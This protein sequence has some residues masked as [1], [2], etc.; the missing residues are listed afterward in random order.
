MLFV[1]ACAVL[2][3]A[4]D[5][6][7]YWLWAR[8]PEWGYWD[9]PPAVGWM[10]APVVALLP[11]SALAFRLVGLVG[12]LIAVRLVAGVARDLGEG[13]PG[14]TELIFLAG[15]LVAHY[16]TEMGPDS[17]LLLA[18]GLSLY[19]VHRG[20]W[21]LAG[22]GLAL[23]VLSKLSGWA[24]FF[25]FFGYLLSS[26]Q[27]RTRGPWLALFTAILLLIPH[28]V[29]NAQHD[30]LNYTFQWKVRSQNLHPGAHN[31]WKTLEVF[32]DMG[33]LGP[34]AFA[35]VVWAW[36]KPKLRILLWWA[37]PIQIFFLIVRV[38]GP[39]RWNWALPSY[40]PLAALLALWVLEEKRK[41]YRVALGLTLVWTAGSL[42]VRT[43]PALEA[44]VADHAG[45]LFPKAV[46]RPSDLAFALPAVGAKLSEE[47][48]DRFL[49]CNAYT[50]ASALSFY[51]GR[52]VRTVRP[53]NEGSQ[54]LEYNR[55]RELAGQD[56]LLI[57]IQPLEELGTVL[58]WL[59]GSF[60][61]YKRLPTWEVPLANGSVVRFYP[62][63]CKGFRVL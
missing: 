49:V 35:A 32:L 40:L 58:D 20:A 33:F 29:W 9:H 18:W 54:F 48:S 45:K 5:E 10:A 14:Q 3:L 7:Y 23:A 15:P 6:A 57:C 47:F 8:H 44:F 13:R 41:L 61:S 19:G 25:C 12:I 1:Y 59:Q 37:L 51:S 52:F 31:L 4:G 63:E 2:P 38:L 11:G 36:S 17:P 34:L 30:W 27:W 60:E 22:V 24:L 16:C 43:Q 21:L 42:L 55:W 26:G 39:G 56:A 50:E 28:F 46:V 62:V 53:R